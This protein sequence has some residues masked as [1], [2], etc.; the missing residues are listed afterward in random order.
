MSL[1]D[2]ALTFS[3]P[4]K[5]SFPSFVFCFLVVDKLIT[6]DLE[7]KTAVSFPEPPINLSFPNPPTN[8]SLPV[9]PSII[10]APELPVK[11]LDDEFPVALISELP[12]S[13]RF[14]TLVEAV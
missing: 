2:P 13:V 8:K 3:I 5:V 1:P 7:L 10:F 6:L 4:I 11:I 12:V 14:S 9:P